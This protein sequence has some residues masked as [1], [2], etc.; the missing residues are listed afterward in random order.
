[1]GDVSLVDL[2]A[3]PEQRAVI[4]RVTGLMSLLEGHADVVMDEAGPEVIGSP[5]Q[6]RR[7]FN[8]RR[9][10]EGVLDRV[11]R[12]LLGRDQKMAHHRHGA[13]FVTGVVDRVGYDGFNAVWADPAH[14]PSKD[15]IADPGAWVRR[16]HG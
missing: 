5:Q 6:I 8:R 2:F 16:V 9:K 4:E 1:T 14:L 7:K 13:T 12:R 3:G 15:E 11:L 10:G